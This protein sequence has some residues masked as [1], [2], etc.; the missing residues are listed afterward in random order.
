MDGIEL[1]AVA[2][3]PAVVKKPVRFVVAAPR[4]PG[5][6]ESVLEELHELWEAWEAGTT[7]VLEHSHVQKT[8]TTKNAKILKCM[9]KLFFA[10]VLGCF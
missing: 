9:T 2:P 4:S 6:G 3:A 10:G 7:F 1:A 8:L 5:V